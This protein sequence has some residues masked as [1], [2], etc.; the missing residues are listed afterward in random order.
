M[1]LHEITNREM[2]FF[3]SNI[4][5]LG[6]VSI[7]KLYEA[8]PKLN[9]IL[10]LQK[11]QLFRRSG[12][13]EKKVNAILVA[14][15]YLE[16][17]LYRLQELE[18]KGIHFLTVEDRDFPDALRRIPQRPLYLYI[19][20]RCDFPLSRYV[21]IVGSRNASHYGM[22]LAAYIAKNLAGRGVG[23]ISGMALGIDAAAHKGA[24]CA[25]GVTHAVL[26]CGVNICYPQENFHLYREILESDLGSIVSEFPPD[27]KPLSFHFPLRNRIISGLSDMVIVV[28]AK[29]RSGS[30]I[31]VDH[32][33]EQGKEV[34]AVPGRVTDPMSKGCNALIEMGAS[35]YTCVEDLL[36]NLCV[37]MTTNPVKSQ[38][39]INMLAN[40]EKMVYSCVDLEPKYIDQIV[41]EVGL[42]FGEVCTALLE[43]ELLGMISQISRNY[44]GRRLE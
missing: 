32:A 12:L 21:S 22:E 7:L 41:E 27:T 9:E 17:D 10:I 24:I 26:G 36:S 13:D 14:I 1:Q 2:F 25:G 31:T 15:A 18:E 4:R 44:Y 29:E 40:N 28:E 43:L 38:K 33:L 30:L 11:E 37:E 20:G 19:K 5:L 3:L 6:A 42:S 16:E 35:M 34:Y 8:F 23:I 39:N